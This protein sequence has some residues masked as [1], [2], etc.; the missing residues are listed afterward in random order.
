MIRLEGFNIFDNFYLIFKITV[1]FHSLLNSFCFLLKILR[2]HYIKF[3]ERLKRYFFCKFLFSGLMYFLISGSKVSETKMQIRIRQI[4]KN[5]D[6][7][8]QHGCSSPGAAGLSSPG[9]LSTP[10]TLEIY[11]SWDSWV[12]PVKSGLVAPFLTFPLRSDD[13]FNVFLKIIFQ[14]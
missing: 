1:F 3:K 7:G 6:P 10:A 11:Y 13:L 8:P 12:N 9:S 2:I 5:V 14:D 4:W